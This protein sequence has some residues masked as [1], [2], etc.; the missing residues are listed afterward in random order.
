[1][2]T[3]QDGTRVVLKLHEV[4][5]PLGKGEDGILVIHRDITER[6]RIEEDLRRRDRI[7]SAVAEAGEMLLS[8][9]PWEKRFNQALEHLGKAASATRVAILENIPDP[10]GGWMARHRV[11]WAA[12][13]FSFQEKAQQTSFR[14]LGLERWVDILGAKKV[15][16]AR[17]AD[18]P[19]QEQ[20]FFRRIRCQSVLAIPIFT[21]TEW[22][23]TLDLDDSREE[24]IW[25]EA[26]IESLTIAADLI[27]SAIQQE[28][29]T[30]AVTRLAEAVTIQ[31]AADFFQSLVTELYNVLGCDFAFVGE[32]ISREP[33]RVQTLAFIQDGT[34]AENFTYDLKGTPCEN[35]EGKAYQQYTT[36][37]QEQFPD[38]TLLQE[39]G[40]DSYCGMPLFSAEEQPLGIIVVM[41]RTPM[42][43]P[44]LVESLLKIFA[45][46]AGAELE[47]RRAMELI[48]ES[49]EKFRLA[50]Q[51]SPDAVNI[52]RLSDGLY[53]EINEGFTQITG[54]TWDD[55]RGKTSADIQIWDNPEDRERLVRALRDKGV[56][57]NL[58]ARFRFKDGTVHTGLMSARVIQMNGEPHILS[59]TRDIEDRY[60]QEQKI[61]ESEIRYRKLVDQT[62]VAIGIHSGGKWRFINQEGARLMG[63]DSYEELLGTPVLNVVH[64]DSQKVALERIRYIAKTG[65]PVP[66]AEEK[67]LRKDGTTVYTL[68]TS[69]PISYKG[70]PSFQVTALDITALK[71]AESEIQILTEAVEQ[72]PSIV[73][74]TDLDGR[75]EYVNPRFREVTGYED[76]E[77]I[78]KVA[79]LMRKKHH[80]P[81]SYRDLWETITSGRAWQGEF[82]NKKKDGT[83]YWESATISPVVDVENQPRHFL[84][85]IEDITEKKETQQK[86]LESEAKFRS[87]FE[88]SL[89]TIFLS[90]P[91]ARILDINQAGEDLFGYSRKELL[92]MNARD[93]YANPEDR[94]AF[95]DRIL[96]QGYV[97]DYQVDLRRKDGTIRTCLLTVKALE[98]GDQENRQLAGLIHDITDRELQR[99]Q[100]EEAL[101][102]AQEGERVKT[103]FLANMS[104]EIRTPL[105]SILGFVDVLR[106]KEMFENQQE[107]NEVIDIIQASGQRLMRT[108][109]EI[110]DISQLE[111]GAFTLNPEPL[112]L[113]QLIKQ[114]TKEHSSTIKMRGLELIV[115]TEVRKPMIFGDMESILKALSNLVDNA[116][117]YTPSGTIQI[118]LKREQGKYAVYVQDSGIGISK[119]YMQRMYEAFSQEST[120]FT[121]KYQGL[122]LGLSITKRCL[123]LNHV[124]ISVESEKE[125]GTTFRLEFTPW[126]P[127]TKQK[128]P[129]TRT[130]ELEP[131]PAEVY[132]DVLV[133]EDDPSSQMLM[134]YFLKSRYDLSYAVSVREALE[135]LQEKQ[136]LIVLL[137]VSLA[138]DEDGL[139]LVRT[140]RSSDQW[141]SIPVIALT[142]H[143]FVTD[144]D[145]CLAAGCNDYL[146]KPV[147]QSQLL[148]RIQELTRTSG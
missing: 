42:P 50:F 103:L 22:W 77:V 19:P 51:T 142:A 99:R 90:T 67:L 14:E 60:V 124:P 39:M 89:D 96:A 69:S 57:A 54:Y 82:L 44:S 113:N 16:A 3:R 23:G 81:E 62:P 79:R 129:Q 98:S 32:L 53:V 120:G 134:E 148:E 130:T 64:P 85:A 35:V 107:Q 76:D 33:E 66:I 88:E 105:N 49:E 132:G 26:E 29:L 93:L 102:K 4:R 108:V 106:R 91:E 56:C 71:E 84:L 100:L 145:R 36:H 111:A 13:G 94:D 121:K 83:S 70:E 40:I 80:T 63:Y 43:N 2:N 34:P 52:N 48:T 47:R 143:A 46:R 7:L 31:S 127:E 125:K 114:V 144:R 59:I 20:A 128:K 92:R 18:L 45:V 104:H 58:E 115:L 68:V 38:D 119:D 15:I 147:R 25:T 131:P 65:K 78:G 112:N 133:V 10:E 55:V 141:K 28:R 17:V 116:I 123:D 95:V 122:G 5:I 136:P 139:D 109:H 27:G 6:K 135:I 86:L 9:T 87:I 74:I 30:S 110:L 117:K 61:R 73:M 72:S 97:K 118:R 21:G 12:S 126:K 101:E 138:G 41:S 8:A 37:I 75:I 24:R 137:D 1:E 140:M 11:H 146:S